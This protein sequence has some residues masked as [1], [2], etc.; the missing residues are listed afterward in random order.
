MHEN[1]EKLTRIGEAILTSA[2]NDLYLSMRFLDIALSG[3]GYQMNLNTARVG[4]DGINIL[5]NPAF[6]IKLYQEDLVLL[7]RYYLHIV[8]HC[9]FRHELNRATVTRICGTW[10]AT[11]PQRTCWTAL[12]TRR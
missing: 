8:L 11:L 5:Y 12:T 2:R 3:L 7:N 1:K 4:T 10:P 6:L 9:M